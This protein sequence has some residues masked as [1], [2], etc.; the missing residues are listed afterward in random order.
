MGNSSDAPKEKRVV[1]KIYYPDSQTYL[2]LSN[3]KDRESTGKKVNRANKGFMKES[4]NNSPQF[5]F[6]AGGDI[7][8]PQIG[9][10][11]MSNT[12]NGE[13]NSNI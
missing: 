4:Q 8:N 10:S 5:N 6:T 3:V 7:V 9:S 2:K 11:N 13:N 1:L 12:Q